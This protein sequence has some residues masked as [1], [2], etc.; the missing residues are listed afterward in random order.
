[1]NS[2]MEK[3]RNLILGMGSCYYKGGIREMEE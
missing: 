2:S 3:M 1:M